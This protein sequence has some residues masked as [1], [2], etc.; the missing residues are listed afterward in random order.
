MKSRQLPCT[1]A[2]R[3]AGV[4]V[5]PVPPARDALLVFSTYSEAARRH[6]TGGMSGDASSGSPAHQ[7]QEWRGAL[8]LAE[9]R[10]LGL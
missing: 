5:C 7:L 10:A 3:Q 1:G 4:P 8:P 2:V 6:R 9:P